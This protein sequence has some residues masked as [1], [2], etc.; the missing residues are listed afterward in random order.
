M[1]CLVGLSFEITTPDQLSVSV[2][3]CLT[4]EEYQPTSS[5]I[6]DVRV[7]RRSLQSGWIDIFDF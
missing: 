1:K 2:K 3:S 7:S 4:R 6:D 5:D